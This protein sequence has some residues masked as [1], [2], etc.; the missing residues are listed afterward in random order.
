M[1]ILDPKPWPCTI[2]MFIICI[3]KWLPDLS[4]VSLC[5]FFGLLIFDCLKGRSDHYSLHYFCV[6]KDSFSILMTLLL[7]IYILSNYLEWV[8]GSITMIRKDFQVQGA[9]VEIHPTR[10]DIPETALICPALSFIWRIVG[11]FDFQRCIIGNVCVSVSRQYK[12][13]FS[14]RGVLKYN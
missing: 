6:S 7:P 14:F 5:N 1:R 3:L 2:M 8:F 13:I 9:E 4:Y 12:M 11:Y 10:G